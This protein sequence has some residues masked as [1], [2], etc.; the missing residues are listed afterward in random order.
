MEETNVNPN[1]NEDITNKTTQEKDAQ[2]L[3]EKDKFR[4][5][6]VSLIFAFILILLFVVSGVYLTINNHDTVGGIIFSTTIIGVG[7]L[8]ITGAYSKMQKP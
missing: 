6:L 8:F 7:G 3:K 4:L 1:N 2:I 5:N